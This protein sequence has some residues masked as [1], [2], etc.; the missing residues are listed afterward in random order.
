M[1][2][3]LRVEAADWYIERKQTQKTIHHDVNWNAFSTAMEERFTDCQE[4][5]KDYEKPLVLEDHGDMQTYLAKF[6][7]LNSRVGLSGQVLKRVIRTAITP[8]MY[9]NIM[10][11]PGSI[12]DNDAD[13]LGAVR[14]AGIEEEELARALA[15]KKT[16]V[17][18]QKV[19]DAAPKGKQ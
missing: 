6:I 10:R 16:I 1:R 4:Q 12:P 8:D 9:K 7:E 13:L 19:K 11:K 5:G 2:T 15:A 18:T 3:F 17:R 14:E